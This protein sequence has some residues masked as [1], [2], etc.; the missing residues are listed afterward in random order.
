MWEMKTYG[1]GS[2]DLNI[3]G[4]QR[5]FIQQANLLAGNIW[6]LR[7]GRGGGSKHDWPKGSD[8][9]FEH[10]CC[11]KKET[12]YSSQTLCLT[13]D[14]MV[15]LSEYLQVSSDMTPDEVVQKI[16]EL[17][18]WWPWSKTFPTCQTWIQNYLE[19]K[20]E[21]LSD[22][23]IESFILWLGNMW[24]ISFWIHSLVLAML[25]LISRRVWYK[26]ESSESFPD[27]KPNCFC[28]GRWYSVAH[29]W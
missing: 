7:A 3:D 11:R 24:K 16:L 15:F 27:R 10:D 26:K 9:G 17:C 22:Q 2:C 5:R 6:A 4:H 1:G 20:L 28:Q 21:Q 14:H 29:L 23:F 8:V 25:Y 19:I 18:H 13:N 12:F